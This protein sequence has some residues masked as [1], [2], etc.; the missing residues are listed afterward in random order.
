MLMAIAYGHRHS[1]LNASEWSRYPVLN[2]M[3]SMAERQRG[4]VDFRDLALCCQLPV[5]YL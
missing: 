3:S 5:S 2:E 1:P 4:F